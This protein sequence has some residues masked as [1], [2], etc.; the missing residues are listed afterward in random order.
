MNKILTNYIQKKVGENMA[1]KKTHEEYVAE[2]AIKNPNVEVIGTY[3]DA[4]TPISHRCK[5]HNVLWDVAPTNILRG[6]G[7]L[8][9][10]GNVKKSHK[11]YVEEVSVINDNID[12]VGMYISANKKITHRCK[13][14]GYEWDAAPSVILRGNGCPKCGGTMK[15]EH[16]QYVNELKDINQDVEVIG[17]YIN[18]HTKILHKCKIDGYCWFVKPTHMLSGSI[19][20]KCNE[21][22]LSDMYKKQHDIY[23]Q[24]L[25]VVNPDL[26]VIDTYV[27]AKTPI[28][29]RCKIDGYEWK[30][31]PSNVLFGQGCPICQETN[32]ERQIRQWLE[33]NHILYVYQKTFDDCKDK[34]V[35]PFDFYLPNL[36]ILI[37]FDG[38]QHFRPVDFSGHN[39]E[40]SFNKF[41]TTQYHDNIKTQYCMDNNIKL[42]R[43]PYF[44]N[45]EIELNNFIHLI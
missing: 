27:N 22:K 42:L 17:E 3:I 34:K 44:K 38:E 2:V 6:H 43:I 39:K 29:H 13:I 30:I 37:E 15:K 8:M 33:N 9:C 45:I 14:D 1:K 4:R 7:C 36:N 21:R 24:Q 26:E 25:L 16:E 11:Q 23:A 31:T 41:E 19:C 10:G 32:G 40:L 20:P 18:A 35:L 28:L 5:L 12:V